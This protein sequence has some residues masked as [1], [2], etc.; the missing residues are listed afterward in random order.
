MNPHGVPIVGIIV[1]G[2]PLLIYILGALSIARRDIRHPDDFFIAYRKVGV[3]A[4]SSASVAYAFQVSTIYPFLLWGASN[5][6]FVPAVNT[7][8]WG[9][10]ILL[11]YSCFDR[12]KQFIGH[13]VTLHG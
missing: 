13:D 1:I 9:L 7:I 11:F 4:F 5:F 2:I 6:Y 10:G 3:T 12:Y 8:C